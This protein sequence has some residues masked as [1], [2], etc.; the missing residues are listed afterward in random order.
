MTATE[1]Q[2]ES[3][4][5]S[6]M[7]RTQPRGNLGCCYLLPSTQS[8]YT[9]YCHLLGE[10]FAWRKFFLSFRVQLKYLMTKESTL[11]YKPA[12]HVQIKS[13]FL[14]NCQLV[15]FFLLNCRPNSL[16]WCLSFT[17]SPCRTRPHQYKESR[18]ERMGW[19]KNL[20]LIRNMDQEIRGLKTPG[21]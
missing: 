9:F 21:S 20:S 2:G 4:L 15:L 3:C 14:I 11:I 5:D 7:S 8:L 10:P 1:W 19:G 18:Q 6:L 12:E 17:I 16:Q 13:H